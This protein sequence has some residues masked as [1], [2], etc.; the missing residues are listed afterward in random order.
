MLKNEANIILQRIKAYYPKFYY[1]DYTVSNW[2]MELKNYDP[3]NI[4]NALRIYGDNNSEPPGVH[5]LIAIA[6]RINTET[7]L[8]Y[9]T[10]C[11]YC[12]R[13]LDCKEQTKHEDRC[14]S[15]RYIERKY[16]QMFN[17][18]VDK[19]S[20]WEMS[21]EDFEEKYYLFLQRLYNSN[22]MNKDEKFYIG[23]YFE[24]FNKERSDSIG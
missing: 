19:K 1:D 12:G 4:I 11:K 21:E 13:F 15:I 3:N 22:A 10:F 23:K 24:T 9:E 16:K 2:Y 8:E 6:S 18:E 14:R 17:K 20:L 7:P 5:Q